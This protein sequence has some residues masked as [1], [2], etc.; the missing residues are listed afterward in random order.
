[1]I[2]VDIYQE[3]KHR[4]LRSWEGKDFFNERVLIRARVL[5]TEE[6]IGDP[7][8]DDFPLQKGKEKLMQAEFAN[9]LGQAFTDQYGD[10]EGTLKDILHMDLT[11]NFRRAIFVST[12]NAVLRYTAR[13]DGTV[14]CRNQEPG[15]CATELVEYLKSRYGNIR[16]GQVGFQPRMVEHLSPEFPIRVLDM[17]PDN[18]GSQKFQVTIEGSDSTEDVIQWAD[19]LFVT[20]TTIVNG[21]IGRFLGRKPVIFY[22]TT[23]AGPAHLMGWERFCACST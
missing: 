11:N 13:I 2:M 19:I 21:T 9:A 14:H 22:G 10:F 7:E 12:L 15:K 1:M 8:A 6:A 5:S 17:D 23:I 20:G 3:L 4:A 18:I 16:I